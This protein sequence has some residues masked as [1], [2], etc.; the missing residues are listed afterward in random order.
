MSASVPPVIEFW[1]E[2]GSNYSYLTLMRIEEEVRRAGLRLAWKPFLL[3]PIFRELGYENAPFVQQKE[4]GEYA[5]RDVARRA[6]KYGLAFRRPSEF[7][8]TA[9]PAMRVA[10][11]A[12][13]EPWIGEF[14]RRIMQ[15]NWVRD[16]EIASNE[17]ALE[18]LEGL[19]PDP[20]AVLAAALG[21]AN[22]LALREQTAQARRRG[23][24]GA[25][26]FF[27]GDEMFW[28]DDR[29]EDAIAFARE[30]I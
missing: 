25:P 3:G 28:G 5:W 24:F 10:L 18:A 7:P 26:T 17:A 29:L 9:L 16:L 1:F 4:K 27:V 23:V 11:L 13:D 21:E 12:A 20:Q 2:F 14:C 8:R 15:R 22:K 30:Q 6:A 19:A